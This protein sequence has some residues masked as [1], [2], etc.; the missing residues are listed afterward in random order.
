MDL[1]NG[2]NLHTGLKV[3]PGSWTVCDMEILDVGLRASA[4]LESAT[5]VAV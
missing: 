1:N 5:S 3:L 4:F 2:N